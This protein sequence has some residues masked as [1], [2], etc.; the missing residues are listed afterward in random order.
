MNMKMNRREFI[1]MSAAAAAM[2]VW[3]ATTANFRDKNLKGVDL[4]GEEIRKW[5]NGAS[6]QG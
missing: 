2:P 6:L 3:R 4:V 1:G 5:R